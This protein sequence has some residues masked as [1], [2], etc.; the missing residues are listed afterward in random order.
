[1]L[2]QEKLRLKSALIQSGLDKEVA[3]ASRHNFA[4]GDRSKLE[5]LED[6][7]GL[8]LVQV[9]RSINQ[10]KYKRKQRIS[11]RI[12]SLISLGSCVFLT[13]T[14]RN[15]VLDE[16][17]AETRRRYVSRF[18]KECSPAYVANIDFGDDG[19]IHEYKADDGTIRVSTAREHYHAIVFVPSVDL[20][21]WKHGIIN[22]KRINVES[23]DIEAV[24]KYVAKLSNHAMKVNNGHAPRMIYSRT[25]RDAIRE[26][27]ADLF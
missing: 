25:N 26:L 1:M 17:T 18:L 21:G 4:Y 6:V 14:F 24:T 13:L 7:Y 22:A 27:F 9:A 5:E 8:E 19:N 16:T 3:K 12:G 10:S 11:S 15:E 23:D 20:D 2:Q